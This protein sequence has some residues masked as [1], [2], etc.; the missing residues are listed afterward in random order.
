[1]KHLSLSQEGQKRKWQPPP[2]FLLVKSHGQRHQEGY[3]PWGRERVGHDIARNNNPVIIQLGS[4][5]FR[6]KGVTHLFT[7]P[8]DVY[9]M[10]TRWQTGIWG[11]GNIK[12]IDYKN[13]KKYK[14]EK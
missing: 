8:A 13:I 7:D 1:M 3:S 10:H 14:K 9:K 4:E 6:A 2:G 5:N 12:G 11:A